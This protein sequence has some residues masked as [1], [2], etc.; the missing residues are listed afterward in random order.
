MSRHRGERRGWPHARR[1]G[2]G[3]MHR[4]LHR[5]QRP[6]RSRLS[7]SRKQLASPDVIDVICARH[8]DAYMR[9][10][11]TLDPDVVVPHHCGFLRGIDTA[12]LNQLTDELE[13]DD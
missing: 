2:C 4:R 11:L 13:V 10:T 1:N 5:W 7:P 12:R 9:T 3:G 8:H 6:A